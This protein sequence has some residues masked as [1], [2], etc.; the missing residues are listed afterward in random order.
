M[1][2]FLGVMLALSMMIGVFAG[3]SSNAAQTSSTVAS[4]AAASDATTTTKGPIAIVV[5]SG[6]HGV[7]R[8]A[9]ILCTAKM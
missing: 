5:P 3:C 8:R 6:D 4:Q 9:G 2:R 7:D 1:K